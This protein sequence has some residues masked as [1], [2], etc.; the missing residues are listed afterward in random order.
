MNPKK[1]IGEDSIPP[2]LINIA[3]ETLITPLSTGTLNN[4][5]Y[6]VLPNKKKLACFKSLDKKTDNKN[7]ASAY[8]P[9]IIL[10]T[11]SKKIRKVRKRLDCLKNRCY[12][13]LLLSAYRKLYFVPNV[14]IW[15]LEDW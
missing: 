12:L 9:I 13:F 4:F 15:L 8:Q 1:A 6:S 10:N 2:A 11:F 3:A 7:E 14:F 5:T